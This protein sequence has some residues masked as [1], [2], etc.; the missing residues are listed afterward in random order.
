MEH[1]D[2]P[3]DL[4]LSSSLNDSFGWNLDDDD[5]DCKQDSRAFD[6]EFERIYSDDGCN[7]QAAGDDELLGTRHI[8][9]KDDNYDARPWQRIHRTS[10]SYSQRRDE[11]GHGNSRHQHFDAGKEETILGSSVSVG[12]N[13]YHAVNARQQQSC[14]EAAAANSQQSSLQHSK[15]EPTK[16]RSNRES[17]FRSLP[18]QNNTNVNSMISPSTIQIQRQKKTTHAAVVTPNSSMFTYSTAQPSTA[19]TTHYSQFDGPSQSYPMLSPCTMHQSSSLAS[20]NNSTNRQQNTTP[21]RGILR[22]PTAVSSFTQTTITNNSCRSRNSRSVSRSSASRHRHHGGSRSASRS[23]SRH[24][25]RISRQRDDEHH[26]SL[27]RGAQLI[28]EQLMRS[29]AEVDRSREN[30][31]DIAAKDSKR[32]SANGIAAS[33]ASIDF[34]Y[35]NTSSDQSHNQFSSSQQRIEVVRNSSSTASATD[36]SSVYSRLES[37]SQRLDSL[38]KIFAQNSSVSSSSAPSND[39]VSSRHSSQ[40]GQL[41]LDQSLQLQNHHPQSQEQVNKS[42][43]SDKENEEYPLDEEWED[44]VCGGNSTASPKS[45]CVDLI[46]AEA[47]KSFLKQPSEESAAGIEYAQQYF[48]DN[49]TIVNAADNN[50]SKQTEQQPPSILPTPSQHNLAAQYHQQKQLRLDKQANDALSHARTSGSL[51]RSLVGNHVR[52]PSSWDTILPPT[53][54]AIERPNLKWSK[55]HYPARHRVKGDRKLNS[56][57]YGVR[58]RRSGGRILMNIL[59]REMH[60]PN[61]CR[62]IAI[63][64]FHPNAKGIRIGD[65]IPEVEDVREV[66]MGVRWV[67]PA[68][69]SE[70]ELDNDGHEEDVECFIDGFLTQKRGMLDYQTMGSPLGQRKA[71]NNENVRAVFGD[72]PPLTTVNLYEDELAEVIKANDVKRLSSLP[73]LMLLKLFLFSK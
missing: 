9:G 13:P 31:D 71:V 56:G 51:W 47:P 35:S 29:M 41:Q 14:Q 28:K 26:E 6:E 23:V 46:S 61:V 16:E 12:L 39:Y 20:P 50:I 52:F 30:Q 67:I 59:V 1:R 68:H 34:D 55:W 17:I 70:P 44:R 38:I 54:P 5:D 53:A 19:T 10:F 3:L 62:E 33:D 64:C 37:E 21:Q 4:T 69:C 11:N 42:S 36:P 63:G 73:G 8:N 60:S 2:P 66:W 32:P 25:S 72:Q 27:F 7:N 18:S 57:E 22:N 40:H 49:S 45:A 15:A 65:V 43:S 58:N 24:G 48:Q